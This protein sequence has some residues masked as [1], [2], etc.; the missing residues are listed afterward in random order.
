MDLHP[1]AC[2]LQVSSVLVWRAADGSLLQR[3][4]ATHRGWVT[5][6]SLCSESRIAATSSVDGTIRTWDMDSGA[7]TTVCCVL[8]SNL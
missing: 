1:T 2:D 3:V 8:C 4:G 7:P 6:V 5:A